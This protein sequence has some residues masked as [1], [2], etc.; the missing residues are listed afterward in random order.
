VITADVHPSARAGLRCGAA[1]GV[2]RT[3]SSSVRRHHPRRL[4]L[5]RRFYLGACQ[6]GARHAVP[7]TEPDAS[8]GLVRD[9]CRDDACAARSPVAPLRQTCPVGPTHPV[10]PT[11]HTR[12]WVSKDGRAGAW[13]S[14]TNEAAEPQQ[15]VFGSVNHAVRLRRADD[16]E[17]PAALRARATEPNVG[18]ETVLKD[19][20]R[21]GKLQPREDRA[22]DRQEFET[23]PKRTANPSPRRFRRSLRTGNRPATKNPRARGPLPRAP[24]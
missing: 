19:L 3:A 21:R 22:P 7:L 1:V 20:R 23:L 6:V 12:A 2:R 17:G 18:F 16:A 5:R 9:R 14:R 15:S 13:M 4:E 24:K 8:E 10:A 11:P